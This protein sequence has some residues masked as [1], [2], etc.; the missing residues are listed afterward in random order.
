MCS[1]LGASRGRL[2]REALLETFLLG[3]AAATVG[4]LLATS[5]IQLVTHYLPDAFLTRT[6]TPVA[7]NWRAVLVT[8]LLGFIAAAI[9]GVVPAW[10]ATRVDALESLRLA[11][12]A[13]TEAPT[14]RRLARGLLVAEVALAT[15]LLAGAGLLVRTFVNLT[16]A[17]RGLN[18]DGVITGWVSLPAFSFT[19]RASRL[20]FAREL[21]ERLR[22]L[23]GVQSASLSGGIP[24]A[25]GNIYFGMVQSDA[26]GARPIDAGEI[27]AY[28]VSSQFFELFDIKLLAGRAFSAVSSPDDLILGERLAR[29]LWPNGDAVGRSFQIEGHK[30]WY[31]VIGIA[32]EIRNPLLDPRQDSAEIYHPL[33]VD[34]NGSAEAST[35]GSGNVF[36]ALR[37]GDTCPGIPVIAQAIRSVSPQV[38]IATLGPMDE[39]YREA[40]ARP[41]AAAALGMVFG[42]VA[43]LAAAGGLFSVL[44]AAVARRQREF[45][46][47]VALGLAPALL[48][49]LVL[50]DA[51]E[52]TAIGLG[53][54]LLGAWMLGRGL[55]ALTYEVSAGDPQSL[56]GV[57]AALTLSI[58]VASWRPAL[59]AARVDPVALLRED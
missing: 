2:L 35:F 7:L 28:S 19:D 56:V 4:L 48:A 45:G 9:A 50:I 15:T 49:R 13:G 53:A 14:R 20:T 26:E 52:L 40:L 17:D 8:S 36:L 42:L 37:C 29:V 16:H 57:C 23:P 30:S 41:R 31:R 55:A 18:S 38:V 12:R 25:H 59:R 58:V 22:A 10:M 24:P 33:V 51:L 1:A 6:L 34:R 32:R 5:L 21:E 27:I 44:S 43:L 54:G 46:I 3:I 39:E 47:R 11:G